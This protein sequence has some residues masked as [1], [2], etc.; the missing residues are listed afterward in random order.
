MTLELSSWQIQVFIRRNSQDRGRE[1]RTIW[2]VEE[3]EKSLSSID[4][5]LFRLFWSIKAFFFP[6]QLFSFCGGGHVVMMMNALVKFRVSFLS[7]TPQ[8]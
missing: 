1:R 7:P 8:Q 6:K 3:E 2:K 4:G 5:S